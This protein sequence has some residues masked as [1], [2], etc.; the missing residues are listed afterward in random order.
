MTIR[1][2]PK[3]ANEQKKRSTVTCFPRYKD[4]DDQGY[5]VGSEREKTKKKK[6]KI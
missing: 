2:L 6:E 3:I 5:I 1:T 4:T